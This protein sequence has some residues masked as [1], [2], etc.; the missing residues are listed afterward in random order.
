M[1][2][3]LDNKELPRINISGYGSIVSVYV[4]KD[5]NNEHYVRL[6]LSM[7]IGDRYPMTHE[8][9]DVSINKEQYDILKERLEN[10][11]GERTHLVVKEGSL[12]LTVK[13]VCIN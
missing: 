3:N 11:A 9:L 13:A 5:Q 7:K 8:N 12:E 1:T 4:G 10:A 2:N 6:N